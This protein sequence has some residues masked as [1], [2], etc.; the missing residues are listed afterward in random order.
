MN[1]SLTMKGPIMPLLQLF[2]EICLFRKGPQDVP[3]S[4]FLLRLVLAVYLILG[5]LLLAPD[6]GWVQAALQTAVEIVMNL[7]LVAVL[8]STANRLSRY[9]QT[10][11]ALLATDALIS[12]L[13]LPP[14]QLLA[15]SG[16]GP[17]AALLWMALVAWHVAV[18]AHIVRHALSQPLGVSFAVAVLYTV[19]SFQLM[20]FLF[21]A[22]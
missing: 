2:L 6:A 12:A 7:V 4:G 14:L 5:M 18:M 10:A 15:G 16:A 22:T 1:F 17:L 21:P 8:L 19:V 11:T 13:G 20:A 3:T 9:Q